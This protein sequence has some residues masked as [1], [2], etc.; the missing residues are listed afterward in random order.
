MTRSIPLNSYSQRFNDLY[1]ARYSSLFE[2]DIFGDNYEDMKD[3]MLIS[4]AC[5][6][7]G[8]NLFFSDCALQFQRVYSKILCK[9]PPRIVPYVI[10]PLE[11]SL[12]IF[13]QIS[14]EFLIESGFLFEIGR[15]CSASIP[16]LSTIL[17]EYIEVDVA[18]ISYLSIFAR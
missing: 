9:S 10:R 11:C 17:S 18:L 14:L 16:S 15:T 4:E 13:P 8:G 6:I 3:I 1:N 12:V 5:I 7:S 2:N